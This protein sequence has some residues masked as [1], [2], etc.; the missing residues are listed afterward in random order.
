MTDEW[1]TMDHKHMRPLPQARGIRLACALFLLVA[2][3]LLL[4]DLLYDQQ[5]RRNDSNQ[6]AAFLSQRMEIQL[7]NALRETDLAFDGLAGNPLLQAALQGR[8]Q[9]SAEREALQRALDAPGR[10]LGALGDIRLLAIDCSTLAS[11]QGD[12]SRPLPITTGLCDWLHGHSRRREVYYTSADNHP[13]GG[14]VH[15]W[16]LYDD[17]QNVSGMLVAHLSAYALAPL[18]A[19]I[20]GGPGTDIFIRDRHHRL[21]AAWPEN[22]AT[23]LPADDDDARR[24]VRQEDR[25]QLYQALAPASSAYLYSERQLDNYPLSVTV[26]ID[27]SPERRE[28]RWQATGYLAAWLALAALALWIARR[29]LRQLGLS[30]QFRNQAAA[31]FEEQDRQRVMLDAVPVAVLLVDPEHGII[32]QA[33]RQA[34]QLLQLGEDEPHEVG[35]RFSL[36]PLV[37]WLRQG[38]WTEA[39]SVEVELPDQ[40]RLRV[41]ATLKPLAHGAQAAC[42]LVLQDMSEQQRLEESLATARATIDRMENTDGLTRLANRQSALQALAHEVERCQRYGHPL[43]TASLDIDHFAAFNAR[44]GHEAGDNVL[45]SIAT[46][47]R[48]ATRNTDICARLDG[49]KFLLIFINTPLKQAHRVMTRIGEHI[50]TS[51]FPFAEQSVTFSAS[52]TCWRPGDSTDR[53]LQ[54]MAELI[55]RARA[56]GSNQLYCDEELM[57]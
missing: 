11:S 51:I 5:H 30:A 22:R 34:R 10:R 56:C 9:R 46:L 20:A 37:H 48:D 35:P 50:G 57:E 12:R 16:R 14:I 42:L 23:L 24:I 53:L 36:P 39:S 3:L 25:H 19:E 33:N 21:A 47:L 13:G 1:K 26:G 7:G 18:M 28:W 27:R 43:C 45:L 29:Q 49:E 38:H 54:R 17:R 44:Y 8:P 40:R 2:F 41:L 55:V 6:Y 32:L 31:L 4:A 15:A 52:L